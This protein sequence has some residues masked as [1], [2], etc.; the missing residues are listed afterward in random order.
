MSIATQPLENVI[1][2]QPMTEYEQFFFDLKGFL[3]L[4]GVLTPEDVQRSSSIGQ[5]R[6]Y[7]PKTIR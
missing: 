3:I 4:K 2:A 1:A 6:M 7:S 5:N